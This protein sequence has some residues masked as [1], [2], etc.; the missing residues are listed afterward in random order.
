MLKIHNDAV[1]KGRYDDEISGFV[2]KNSQSV[3]FKSPEYA[4]ED[5]VIY[6]A[7]YYQ[8][9]ENAVFAKDGLDAVGKYCNIESL[10]DSYFRF[11]KRVSKETS[12]HFRLFWWR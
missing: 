7:S 1:K 5:E 9:F 11:I 8:L 2:T 6:I 4:S 12:W 10:V 3:I